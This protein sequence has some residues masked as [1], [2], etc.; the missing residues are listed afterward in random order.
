[1][2]AEKYDVVVVGLGALGSAACH[3]LAAAGLRVLGVERYG[4]VHGPL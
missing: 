1:M 2:T 3:S 4:P